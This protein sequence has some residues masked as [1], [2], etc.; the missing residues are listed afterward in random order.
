MMELIHSIIK[1]MRQTRNKKGQ[2]NYKPN[3]LQYTLSLSLIGIIGLTLILG[4][5]SQHIPIPSVVT[6]QAQESLPEAIPEATELCG[7]TDVVCPNEPKVLYAYVTGYNSVES[8]TDGSPCVGAGGYI[9]GIE[10]V[11]ACPRHLPLGTR[12]ILEG[13]TFKCLDRLAQKYDNRF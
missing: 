2:Y 7:L 4:L 3:F 5:Q 9:C 10:N 8:Q 1:S 13:E 11:V 6:V 12:I